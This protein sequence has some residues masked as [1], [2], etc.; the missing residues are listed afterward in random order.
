MIFKC[1][2]YL[3]LVWHAIHY[4]VRTYAKICHTQVLRFFVR[5]IRYQFVK[6]VSSTC[7]PRW[8]YCIYRTPTSMGN[9][10]CSL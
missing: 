2:K 4:Y 10:A 7:S 9:W 8:S 3:L 1:S 6:I 5:A